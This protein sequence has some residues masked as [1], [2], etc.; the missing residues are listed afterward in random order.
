MRVL[1]LSG[2][3]EIIS[4]EQSSGELCSQENKANAKLTQKR[5]G[6]C[7]ATGELIA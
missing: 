5:N 2:Q 3:I 6:M 1:F 4:R 7:L